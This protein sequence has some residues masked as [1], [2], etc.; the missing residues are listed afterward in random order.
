[1][2]VYTDVVTVGSLLLACNKNPRTFPST[3]FM[4]TIHHTASTKLEI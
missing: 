4:H 3:F 1:M 2:N